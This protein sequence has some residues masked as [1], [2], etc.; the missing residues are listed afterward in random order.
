[1]GIEVCSPVSTENLEIAEKVG[2]AFANKD[3]SA[4]FEAYHDNA[5]IWHNYDDKTL[6]VQEAMER[7]EGVSNSFKEMAFTNVRRFATENGYVQQHDYTFTHVNGESL[8][9]PGCQIV[10]V[11]AG[12]ISRTEA[13]LDRA[14]LN[15][16]LSAQ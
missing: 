13:Y 8:S 10:T 9:F 16:M 7:V 2:T 1:V 11:E 14:P 6:T 4:L 15:A 5:E 12:K 3:I